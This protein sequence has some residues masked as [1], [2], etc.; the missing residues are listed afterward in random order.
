MI[1]SK[2]SVDFFISDFDQVLGK[3][4]LPGLFVVKAAL[5]IFRKSVTIAEHH[6]TSALDSQKLHLPFAGETF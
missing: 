2:L 1:K 6:P 3:F 5:V 4:I